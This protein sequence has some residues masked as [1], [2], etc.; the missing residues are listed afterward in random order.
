M[1]AGEER[2]EVQTGKSGENRE[3]KRENGSRSGA[4]WRKAMGVLL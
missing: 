3:G 4:W 2:S 1:S